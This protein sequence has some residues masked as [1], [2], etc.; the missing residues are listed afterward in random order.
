MP[1]QQTTVADPID[2]IINLEITDTPCIFYHRLCCA[3]GTL[4][5]SRI[6]G[7]PITKCMSTPHSAGVPRNSAPLSKSQEGAQTIT[8][9]TMHLSHFELYTP[10]IMYKASFL[11]VLRRKSRGSPVKLGGM[12]CTDCNLILGADFRYFSPLPRIQY[13]VIR[14]PARFHP[15]QLLIRDWTPSWPIY[16]L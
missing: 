5:F 12:N 11:F 1:S 3:I 4:V 15:L 16:L 10:H 8:C 2:D 7:P 13:C 6:V 9:T 14:S